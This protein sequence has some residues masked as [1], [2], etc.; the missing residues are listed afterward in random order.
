MLGED[1]EEELYNGL[2]VYFADTDPALTEAEAEAMEGKLVTVTGKLFHWY[3]EPEVWK[4]A[5]I[6]NVTDA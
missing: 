2:C 1:F 6:S 4:N 5:V 3:Y